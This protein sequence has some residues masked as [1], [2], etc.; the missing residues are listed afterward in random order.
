MEGN[1]VKKEDQ[2]LQYLIG[3]RGLQDG[4]L[5]S[6][7]LVPEDGA[8]STTRETLF[9]GEIC[10]SHEEDLFYSLNDQA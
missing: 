5:G 4:K 7:R 8:P 1:A 3:L 6:P 10:G 9:T 2:K